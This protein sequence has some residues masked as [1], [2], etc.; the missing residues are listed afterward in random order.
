MTDTIAPLYLITLPALASG[1]KERNLYQEKISMSGIGILKL[2]ILKL[3]NLSLVLGTSYTPLSNQLNALMILGSGSEQELV[4]DIEVK[5]AV[6]Y[7]GK[8]VVSIIC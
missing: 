4:F 3:F 7:S 6:K 8:D 5:N 1:N 2:S